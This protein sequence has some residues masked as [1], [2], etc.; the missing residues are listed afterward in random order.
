MKRMDSIS[1]V[2]HAA[3]IISMLMLLA[4]SVK[5]TILTFED[6]TANNLNVN[7]IANPFGAGQYGSQAASP[8]NSGFQQGD[9]WTPNVSLTWSQGWQ[10]YLG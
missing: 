10:T 5:A 1:A 9:G 2:L 4:S 3:R 8:I 7:S 6:F